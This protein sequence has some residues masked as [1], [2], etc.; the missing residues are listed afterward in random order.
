MAGRI[1]VRVSNQLWRPGVPLGG[2]T[3]QILQKVSGTDYDLEWVSGV[4]ANPHTIA[5]HSDTTATGTE[6]ET[7]TDGSNADPLHVHSGG[8]IWE[9]LETTVMSSLA[10]ELFDPP[11]G[12]SD[13]MFLF[14]GVGLSGISTPALSLSI[15]G[16]LTY[17]NDHNY[18]W[19]HM[20]QTVP[21]DWGSDSNRTDFDLMDGSTGQAG[22]YINGYVH[23][24]HVSS[25][26]WTA[27]EYELYGYSTQTNITHGVGIFRT[28]GAI[29]KIKIFT[30]SVTLDSGKIHFLKRTL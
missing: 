29:D 16:G 1:N 5:S 17:P 19:E 6:L 21:R 24:S 14:E 9:L 18:I 26:D 2:T 28:D 27:V 22:S 25:S 10:V 20:S 3:G 13:L 15:D 30:P 7:L 11:S 8:G 12:V 23:L 4:T